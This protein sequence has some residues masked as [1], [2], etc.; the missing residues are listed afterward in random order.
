MKQYKIWDECS[1]KEQLSRWE[2][3]LRVLRAMTPHERRKH[4]NM[5]IFGEKTEC[6]TV[7]CAVGHCSMD[8]WFRR[9]GFAGKF[10]FATNLDGTP[11]SELVFKEDGMWLS[12]Q[13]PKF[14]GPSEAD[15][16][17]SQNIFMDDTPRSVALVIRQVKARIKV[18]RSL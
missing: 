13:V 4:W 10:R 1:K 5:A 2:N 15:V 18:L 14:F 12:Y 8:P 7:A 6:G 11:D 17:R 9:R 16:N 3:V